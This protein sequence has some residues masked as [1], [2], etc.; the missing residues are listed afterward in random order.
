[1]IPSKFEFRM[2]TATKRRTDKIVSYSN[3]LYNVATQLLHPYKL[4]Q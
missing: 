2:T 4:K 3:H 1:M